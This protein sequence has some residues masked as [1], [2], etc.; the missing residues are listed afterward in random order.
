MTLP[1]S[2]L[3]QSSI[4]DLLA[5]VAAEDITCTPRAV[6]L[7][8]SRLSWQAPTAILHGAT[9]TGYAVHQ[10]VDD[11]PWKPLTTLP[12]T[13]LTYDDAPL[14][15]NR[16]YAWQVLAIWQFPDDTLVYSDAASHGAKPP[17]LTILPVPAPT[18]L[19]A[20][21]RMP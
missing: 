7:T 9:L 4:F 14:K 3:G 11:K 2:A 13:A 5:V 20:E 10:R 1:V 21:E 12:A 17:C 8:G 16:T 18:G 19:Q 6:Y 15:P